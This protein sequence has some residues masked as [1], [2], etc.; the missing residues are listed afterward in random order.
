MPKQMKTLSQKLL[1]RRITQLQHIHIGTGA[2]GL[3][4]P[5]WLCSTLQFSVILAN[6]SEQSRSYNRNLLIKNQKQY[7]VVPQGQHKQGDIVSISDLIFYDQEQDKFFDAIAHPNTYII[8]TALKEA[9]LKPSFVSLMCAALSH[10]LKRHIKKPLYIIC[11]ENIICSRQFRDAV[12]LQI[13]FPLPSY[14]QFLPCVVDRVCATPSVTL[15]PDGYSEVLV[16]VERYAR[17][18]IERPKLTSSKELQKNLTQSPVAKTAIQFTENIEWEKTRKLILIN[19]PH[20]LIAIN[21]R[22]ANYSRLD[23]YLK[24]DADAAYIL[25]DLLQEASDALQCIE[26]ERNATLTLSISTSDISQRFREN[27]DLVNRVLARFQNP[28]QLEAFLKDLYKKVSQWALTYQKE[29]NEAPNQ[30]SRTLFLLTSLI[31]YDR[32]NG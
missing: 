2:L 3:G 16:E 9:V 18:Y 8:T 23:S 21:A 4:L 20:L 10:R 5:V 19:G 22:A 32:Y 17:W 24:H 11:C 15:K 7:R 31:N 29:F 14:I 13:G 28:K 1:K 12:Q 30:T 26:F 6:R 25:E 27:P